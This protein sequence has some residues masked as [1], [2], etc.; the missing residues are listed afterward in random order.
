MFF[1]TQTRAD[2]RALAIAVSIGVATGLG[3]GGAYLMGGL[4]K[5]ADDHARFSRL[6]DAAADGFSETALT[7]AVEDEGILAIARRADATPARDPYA[8]ESDR[9]LAALNDRLQ[10]RLDAKSRGL[11]LRASFGGP[12]NPAATPFH[13]VGALEGSRE[14]DCL[15]QAV[16]YEA[17]GE[18]PAG[19]AAVAQVVL[20]R[21]RNPA[22]PKTICGVV[23]QRA[24]GSGCQFSFACNGS[25]LR[26]REPAAW[27]RSQTV[28]S[29]A[30]DGFVMAEVGAATHFH[31]LNVA[32]MWGPHLMRVAQVGMHVFYR[33]NGRATAPADLADETAIAQAGAIGQGK[34]DPEAKTLQAASALLTAQPLVA[35]GM[36]GPATKPVEPASAPIGA[37]PAQQPQ[38]AEAKPLQ[39]ASVN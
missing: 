29:R 38:K 12:Y 35:G 2:A 33:F 8:A 36:G 30:L 19:Q 14:L 16:Y 17:R 34:I 5:A 25:T 7:H 20:N 15:T 10:Q 1:L 21:A 11:L 39:V 4:A 28:A 24:A 26:S 3:L 31:T 18:T 23:F 9:R 13:F 22:F 32:P 27:R 6:A 37:V